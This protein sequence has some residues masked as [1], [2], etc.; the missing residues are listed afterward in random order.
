MKIAIK[1]SSMLPHQQEFWE[2]KSFMTLLVG[3]YDD[4]FLCFM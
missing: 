2:S 4:F 1:K 3:G